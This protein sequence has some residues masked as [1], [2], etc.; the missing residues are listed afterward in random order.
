VK[1]KSGSVLRQCPPFLPLSLFQPGILRDRRER[2]TTAVGERIHS[3]LAIVRDEPPDRHRSHRMGEDP[4]RGMVDAGRGAEQN[5][6]VCAVS[7]VVVFDIALLPLTA[8]R[9]YNLSR[10]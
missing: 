9:E 1:Q 7:F 5:H 3:A 8:F 10:D 4:D 6:S 2:C